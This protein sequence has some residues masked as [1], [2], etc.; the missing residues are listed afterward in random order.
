M[1]SGTSSASVACRRS[2]SVKVTSA[3]EL[4]SRG[5]AANQAESVREHV[6][7]DCRHAEADAKRDDHDANRGEWLANILNR[8]GGN[9]LET[10][11]GERQDRPDLR[12]PEDT[13]DRGADGTRAL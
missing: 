8:A 4:R 11:T 2:T 13:P 9:Q 7:Q 1:A 5:V 6:S 12:R 3:T 10:N